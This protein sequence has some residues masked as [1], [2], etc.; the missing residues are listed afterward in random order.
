MVFEDKQLK[1]TVVILRQMDFLAKKKTSVGVSSCVM[2]AAK[3]WKFWYHL[4]TSFTLKISD[5][6][7]VTNKA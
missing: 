6:K 7:I 4:L 2:I 5:F 3:K 1:I